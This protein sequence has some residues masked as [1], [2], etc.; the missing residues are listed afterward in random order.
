[1]SHS[2]VFA[3]GS[4]ALIT[5]AASGIGLALA[6]HCFRNGMNVILAD[7]NSDALASAEAALNSEAPASGNA[8]TKTVAMDVTSLS[9]W[10]ALKKT[11][12][13]S[14]KTVEVLVLNA[15]IG[16]RGR[17]WGDHE[18]FRQ[19]SLV[20]LKP[21]RSATDTVLDAG[22]QPLRRS[23]WCQHILAGSQGRCISQED[24]HRHHRQQAGHHQPAWQP[25]LQR[26]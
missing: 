4:T 2:T 24:G 22:D 11:V 3:P 16:F 26:V 25:R 19:V 9:D 17:S 6:K 8:T 1:M 21:R 20:P 23:E 12:A 7:L 15:A 18:Y 13:E 5:G 14:F 10:E